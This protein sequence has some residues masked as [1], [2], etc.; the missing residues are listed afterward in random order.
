MITKTPQSV[1]TVDGKSITFVCS[2]DG[3]PKPR[4]KWTKNSGE[5][6]GGRYS[7]TDS[8]DLLIRLVIV[9]ISNM[10]IKCV[11][12]IFVRERDFE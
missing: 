4:I 5:L 9:Y 11:D 10:Y 6:S 3:V 12:N 2:A 8:G 7:T 1:D